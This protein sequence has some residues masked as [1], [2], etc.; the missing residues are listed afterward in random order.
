MGE[1]LRSRH[2]GIRLSCPSQMTHAQMK[3]HVAELI[4][5]H[6]WSVRSRDRFPAGTRAY[7]LDGQEQRTERNFVCS[8]SCPHDMTN[9]QARREVEQ[10]IGRHSW[11][12]T[13]VPE[14]RLGYREWSKIKPMREGCEP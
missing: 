4:D 1:Q 13:V 8:V 14:L 11:T 7:P 2:F 12:V 3:L 5:R 9:A 10:I 6:S